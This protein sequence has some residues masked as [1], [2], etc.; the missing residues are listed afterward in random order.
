MTIETELFRIVERIRGSRRCRRWTACINTE[1]YADTK[2]EL[3]GA[4]SALLVIEKERVSRMIDEEL[5]SK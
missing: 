5:E 2:L 4:L 3:L 1:L